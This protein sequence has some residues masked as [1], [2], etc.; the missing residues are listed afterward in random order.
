LATL[1]ISDLH[2]GSRLQRSVLPHPEPLERL[3]VAL[4]GVERLILLGDVV[5]LGEGRPAH[6]L[7]VAEPVLAA[8]GR[9]VGGEGEIVLVPGNHDLGLVRAWVRTQAGQLRAETPVP[10][11]AT[12]VLARVTELLAPARVRISYPGV[13]LSDR[14]W[15]THGH[16][17]DRHLLPS[18]TFGVLRGLLGR[19]PRAASTP[20]D[21]E[22]AGG[23]SITRLE[24][25]LTRRLPRPLAAVVEDAAELA[26][27][28]S[29]PGVPRLLAPSMSPLT[30]AVLG[31][32]MR[33]V[34]IPALAGV[35]RNLGIDAEWVL[36]GHVHRLG[37]LAADRPQDWLSPDGELR[38][39][40][41][42]SWVYEPLLLHRARA[43]HP[44]WPGG[45]LRIDPA[46]EPRTV[47]LL[48]DLDVAALTG[49]R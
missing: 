34:S 43:P 13:W 7:R 22:L 26:R 29:M 16:Y 21:Y 15:A 37:P 20:A 24:A 18:A 17:L 35:V 33:R 48:D 5:E 11:S 19:Q 44:Y 2:L 32:Q 36:F 23:P 46:G 6:S 49:S 10:P 47:S 27:A 45:A 39:A 31:L 12:A 30:A 25:L 4:E 28:A 42:G 38:L 9:R 8:L 41:T 14:V 3:L 40:N 1:V